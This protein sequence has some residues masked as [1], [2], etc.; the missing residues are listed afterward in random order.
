ML[1]IA[2]WS[3]E[4]GEGVELEVNWDGVRG[5]F[6]YPVVYSSLRGSMEVVER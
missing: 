2:L 3:R 6:I 5:F 4:D 1:E